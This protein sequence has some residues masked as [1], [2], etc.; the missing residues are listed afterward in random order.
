MR[1]VGALEA[2]AP[3]NEK[4]KIWS[5]ADFPVRFKVRPK[6]MLDPDFG[7]PMEKLES[8]VIFYQGPE[9]AGG[10]KGFLRFSPNHFKRTEDG[11]LIL[12][13][14][15]EAEKNPERIPV[16]PAKL[17]RRLFSAATK[18]GKRSVETLVAIPGHE[19]PLLRTKE[20]SVQEESPAGTD[21]TQTQ[22]LLLTLGAELGYDVWVARNDRGKIFDRGPLGELPRIVSKLPKMPSDAADKTIELIDVLWLQRNSIVAAFEVECTTSIYSGLL[23]MS[24]LISLHPHLNIK[25]FI[26]APDERR[27]KVEQ[28]ILRPTFKL[29]EKPLSEV[30]GFLPLSVLEKKV[31]GVRSLG[32]LSSLKSDFLDQLAERFGEDDATGK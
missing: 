22:H 2:V 5:E 30:C 12:K 17:H 20:Q 21:H 19:T 7:F 11:E 1:W 14:L 8:K 18:K 4:R 23:R 26:V 3:T 27:D 29:R 9:Q 6:V 16:D 31:E 32:L 15:Q 24:D 13:L 25:L 28:E 10:F